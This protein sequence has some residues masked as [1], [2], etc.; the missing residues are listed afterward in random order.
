VTIINAATWLNDPPII[1][2]KKY[3]AIGGDNSEQLAMLRRG[4]TFVDE[5]VELARVASFGASLD[6]QSSTTLNVGGSRQFSHQTF[7]FYGS[8]LAARAQIVAQQLVYYRLSVVIGD[9]LPDERLQLVLSGKKS[10]NHYDTGS[11]VRLD[12]KGW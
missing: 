5:A 12:E 6:A 2:S 10:S 3:N 8:S 9:L 1:I 11:A 7:V 4:E